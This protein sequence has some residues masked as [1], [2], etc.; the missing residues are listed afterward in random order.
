MND[1]VPETGC[2]SPEITRYANSSRPVASPWGRTDTVAP[3]AVASGRG[4]SPAEPNNRNASGTGVTG[5][6][7]TSSMTAGAAASIAPSAGLLDSSSAWAAAGSAGARSAST[8]A[9][10]PTSAA[11]RE[12][13]P[14]RLMRAAAP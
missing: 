14:A 10:R 11:V 7:N 13:V 2:P 9:S 12:R 1:S 8:S 3:V 5:S 4:S 6:L